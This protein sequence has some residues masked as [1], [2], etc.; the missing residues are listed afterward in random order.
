VTGILLQS[1]WKDFEAVQDQFTWSANDAIINACWQQGL[2]VMLSLGMGGGGQSPAYIMNDNV[3]YPKISFIDLNCHHSTYWTMVPSPIPWEPNYLARKSRFIAQAGLHYATHPAVRSVQ[4]QFAS[5][6]QANDWGLPRNVGTISQLSQSDCFTTTGVTI[7]VDQVSD[8]LNVGYTTD[9]MMAAGQ[10]VLNA[11]AYA[12]PNQQVILAV[13]LAPDDT[14]TAQVGQL[15]TAVGTLP[16]GI[17]NWA[18]GL[19]AWGH[20]FQPQDERLKIS[21]ATATDPLVVNAKNDN[22]YVRYQIMANHPGMMGW[23]MGGAATDLTKYRLNN[24]NPYPVGQMGEILQACC[25]IGLTYTPRAIQIWNADTTS[26][27]SGIRAAIL[28][29]SDSIRTSFAQV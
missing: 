10:Q 22:G 14:P 18:Y 6:G 17:M 28:S 2:V 15:D 9:K 4:V 1:A 29:I 5:T 26:A 20:R 19:T 24:G 27:D 25:N 16:D 7:N 13:G 21:N 3:T 12:F 23:Q 8:W 11:T